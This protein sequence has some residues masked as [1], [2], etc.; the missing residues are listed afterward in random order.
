ME[1]YTF[2]FLGNYYTYNKLI[3]IHFQWD[4]AFLSHEEF[5]IFQ[6]MSL[7]GIPS[8][9][10]GVAFE[11]LVKAKKIEILKE[12]EIPRISKGHSIPFLGKG[13]FGKRPR[14]GF[15]PVFIASIEYPSC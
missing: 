6:K 2:T 12:I 7:C 1:V 9:L 10:L 8:L 14:W 4:L 3:Q 11:I 13:T 5:R 15:W